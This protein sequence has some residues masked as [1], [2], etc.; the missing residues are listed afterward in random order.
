MTI[1]GRT[2]VAA[3]AGTPARSVR[4]YGDVLT[5]TGLLILVAGTFLPW[6]RS[7]TVERTSYSADGV[8]RRLLDLHGLTGAVLM[9]WP[10]LSLLCAA[11]LGLLILRVT[12]IAVTL[13]AL[14]ALAAGIVCVRVLT[15]HSNSIVGVATIGPAV[16][17][18]GC[19]VVLG[20][21]VI[22]VVV[23]L[24]HRSRRIR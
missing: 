7:G 6:L 1:T 17:L 10:F 23:M 20:T 2:H 14:C 13:A 8:A 18:A 11:A 19:A 12:R 9:V 4:R 22:S 5:G 15:T 16:T 24:S 3:P 21:A